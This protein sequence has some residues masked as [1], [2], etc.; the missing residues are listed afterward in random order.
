VTAIT[1]RYVSK[2]DGFSRPVAVVLGIA[3]AFAS[4][5]LTA[6]A[7]GGFPLP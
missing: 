3:L 5:L 6:F 7:F 2:S 1:A 4:S